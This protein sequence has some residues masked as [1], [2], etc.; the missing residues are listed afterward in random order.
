MTAQLK[1]RPFKTAE[2][3][4]WCTD[5][6]GDTPPAPR[7]RL[8]GI[9]SSPEVQN[10]VAWLKEECGLDD[11]GAEQLIEYI[12]TGRAVLTE[13]PTQHTIIAER[14]FD[15]GGG[16]QL[17]SMR[18]SAAASIGL[19]DWPCE[20]VSAGD[21]TLSCRPRPPITGSTFCAGRAT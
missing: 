16:M 5:S 2:N 17:I 20:S 1:P 8:R 4:L 14:F 21:S 15:E 10:A 11:S 7:I 3:R 12:V 18:P 13:V 6:A 9:E 19:G